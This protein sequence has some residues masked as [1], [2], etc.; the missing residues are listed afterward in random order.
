MAVNEISHASPQSRRK[1]LSPAALYVPWRPEGPDRYL[2]LRIGAGGDV[3]QSL[4]SLGLHNGH[5]LTFHSRRSG[6]LALLK[7]LHRIVEYI[8]SRPISIHRKP[9][10]IPSSSLGC[11]AL[12]ASCILKE[13]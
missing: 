10:R 7:L 13:M 1:K 5:C 6:P 4:I 8:H 9:Q 3:E 2:P 11:T 12:D